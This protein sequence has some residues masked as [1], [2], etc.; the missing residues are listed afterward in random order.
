MIAFV[1]L[2]GLLALMLL[3]AYWVKRVMARYSTPGDRYVGSGGQLARHLLDSAGLA[4]V[5]TEATDG[6]DHYD[7]VAKAVRLSPGNFQG[8][9]LTAVTVAAHE[10]GHALQ[11]RDGFAPFLLRQRLVSLSISAQRVSGLFFLAAPLL[12]V[13]ARS[14]RAALIPV[15]VGVGGMLLSTLVHL[16]TLPTELDASFRRALPLLEQGGYL[17]AGDLPHARRVLR[18]AAFT[19]V[20]A[21]TASL[22]NLG[23]WISILRR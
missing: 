12:M 7:P 21:S 15:A 13:V 2:A 16:V 18:A 3:P 8:R 9:S 20:A 22:L 19:Y 1:L 4:H 23:R 17:H 5:S 10:V 6:G 14:P 11:D